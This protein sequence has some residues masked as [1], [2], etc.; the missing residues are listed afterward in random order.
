M[1]WIFS[2]LILVLMS[3][4]VFSDHTPWRNRVKHEYAKKTRDNT[5]T[6]A[7]DEDPLKILTSRSRTASKNDNDEI[8]H[9][10]TAYSDVKCDDVEY[11][12]HW[13]FSNYT[14]HEVTNVRGSAAGKFKGEFFK[15]AKVQGKIVGE[16][17]DCRVAIGHCGAIGDITA[18]KK[19]GKTTIWAESSVPW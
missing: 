19:C 3:S 1:K 12:G 9:K 5:Y 7:V 4:I 10:W 16:T 6:E 14:P 18:W 15:N 8:S 11:R 13:G 2:F 17:Y